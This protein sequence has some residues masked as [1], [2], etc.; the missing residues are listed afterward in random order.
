MNS[1]R[2]V[3]LI[4]SRG[5]LSVRCATCNSDSSFSST[6]CFYPYH[7]LSILL[8]SLETDSQLPIDCWCVFTCGAKYYLPALGADLHTF[9]SMLGWRR[10]RDL[11]EIKATF[12][13]LLL[14]KLHWWKLA[15]KPELFL[16]V[17]CCYF[18]T[19]HLLSESLFIAFDKNAPILICL[20]KL[21][22]SL[23]ANVVPFTI[24]PR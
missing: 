12:R 6:V 18:M 1:S 2:E 11:R 7:C 3:V 17:L 5:L 9:C 8:P 16:Q 14:S 13:E 23:L 15:E 20:S 4:S 21:P 10:H 19:F 24:K 22:A